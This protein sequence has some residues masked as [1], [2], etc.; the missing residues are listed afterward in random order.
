V[1]GVL[2]IQFWLS[3]WAPRWSRARRTCAIGDT[4]GKSLLCLSLSL[5]RAPSQ[6]SVGRDHRCCTFLSS[7]HDRPPQ[8]AP[9]AAIR[10]RPICVAA[11]PCHRNPPAPLPEARR[12]STRASTAPY[13]FLSR[14]SLRDDDSGG[15]CG[16][17]VSGL[18]ITRAMAPSARYAID[19]ASCSVDAQTPVCSKLPGLL[20]W[21]LGSML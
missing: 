21:E 1:G 8:S 6:R 9:L 18:P 17:S 11:A 14:A 19:T 5:S 2:D 20:S 16:S 4:Y 3:S 12:L 15:D 7:L 13:H 10:T